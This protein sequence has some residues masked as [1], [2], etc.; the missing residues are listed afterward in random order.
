M[1]YVQVLD[2]KLEMA[3]M[4]I[5]PRHWTALNCPPSPPFPVSMPPS[6]CHHPFLSPGF[7]DDLTRG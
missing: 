5:F 1:Q 4:L 6:V 2:L 7:D 3:G